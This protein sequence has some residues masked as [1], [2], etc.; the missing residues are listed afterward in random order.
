MRSDKRFAKVNINGR[1]SEH[2]IEHFEF[3]FFYK[4]HFEVYMQKPFRLQGIKLHLTII[5]T[6][7]P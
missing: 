2:F 7:P 4:E 5:M 3:F 6:K 1:A